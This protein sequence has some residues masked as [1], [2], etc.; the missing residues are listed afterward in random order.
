MDV[1]GGMAVMIKSILAVTAILAIPVT[2]NQ[3]CP[4]ISEGLQFESGEI[5]PTHFE[6]LVP[7]PLAMQAMCAVNEHGRFENCSF[8]STQELNARQTD[9][10]NGVM[11][12]LL[13]RLKSKQRGMKC[14]TVRV[15]FTHAR[16][17]T[18][19]GTTVEIDVKIAG[20]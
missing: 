20:T 19:N 6:R 8:T 17:D 15:D 7:S 4:E 10:M 3:T 1:A 18:A 11:T 13:R 14:R 16:T 9:T 2:E 5:L 12:R